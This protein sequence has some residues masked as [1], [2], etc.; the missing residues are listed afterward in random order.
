MS[1]IVFLP[2]LVMPNRGKQS[3]SA[4][5][6]DSHS[7]LAS[8]K[9]AHSLI[10]FT[11]FVDHSDHSYTHKVAHKR[12]LKSGPDLIP[13]SLHVHAVPFVGKFMEGNLRGVFVLLLQHGHF[14]IESRL[15]FKVLV[16]EL[17][18]PLSLL[19]FRFAS[20]II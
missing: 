9:V 20:L 11:F 4:H 17:I 3:D 13:L 18:D 16:V 19:Q 15:V 7:N 14:L 2:S 10:L 1:T 5:E 8:F 12:E 6:G